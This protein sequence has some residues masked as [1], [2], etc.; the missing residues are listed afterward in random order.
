K[1]ARFY[2]LAFF[3]LLL[4]AISNSLRLSGIVPTNF[5]TANSLQIGSALESVLLSLADADKIIFMRKEKEKAQVDLI[6]NQKVLIESYARFVPE[7]LLSFLGKDI[8][9]KVHL[10]D[11]VEKSMTV[12][13]SDI[14]SFTTLSESMTPNENFE[15]INTYLKRVAPCIRKHGGYIDKFLG[16][17]IMALFP[18]N[19][20]DAIL[21][22]VEML[23]ELNLLNKERLEKGVQRISIGIGIHTGKQMVG[24]IGEERRLEGTVISDVV[25]TS[26]RLEGLTK[27]YASSLII[28]KEVLEY[29]NDSLKYRLLDKVKVK[30]KNKSVEIY[31]VL[32]GNSDRIINL[33]MK[34]K[35][36]FEKGIR[37]YQ[38][39]DL[40]KALR[41]FKKVIK[42][43]PKDNACELY[44]NRCEFYLKNG[45]SPDWDG[46]E[47]LD[48]K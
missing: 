14:R 32:N 5:L 2:L 11:A 43:D 25:N 46:V 3:I 36:D 40:K 21:A 18:I 39:K 29:K 44:I 6:E 16:D 47:K 13:F 4:G 15:F 20:Q 31:E 23:E 22:S 45:V 27:A 33:K 42:Q 19:P 8:I 38:E 48:F 28:S 24:V 7:E 41:L 35:E 34:T 12:L 26:A 17:G 37:L 1:P 10:G 9:T 30:G